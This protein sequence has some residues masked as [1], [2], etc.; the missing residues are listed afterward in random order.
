MKMKSKF[1]TTTLSLGVVA[2]VSLTVPST[3]YAD[4]VVIKHN[5]RVAIPAVKHRPARKVHGYKH[6][7]AHHYSRTVVHRGPTVVVK[8]NRTRYFRNVY[9]VRPYG[10]FYTG[11]GWY[12]SDNDAF[13]WLAFTAITLKVLDNL[14]E[15][16]QRL[17]EDAQVKATNAKVGEVITWNKSNASG[18][19]KVVRVGTSSSGRQCREFQQKVS[20]GGE[21]EQ[22]YGTACLKA[23]GSWEMVSTDSR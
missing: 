17:H 14:N 6:R 15:E 3:V 19:V 13:K 9:V 2:L 1:L 23:D 22:V 7:N 8:P 4:R 10:R 12:K 21:T 11:Y 16:Q 18:S 20:I 5:K